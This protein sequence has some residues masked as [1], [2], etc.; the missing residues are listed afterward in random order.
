MNRFTM[1]IIS[2]LVLTGAVVPISYSEVLVA[3]TLTG[4][5]VEAIDSEGLKITVQVA[6]GG[7]KLVMPVIS[8][9]VMK[10]VAVGDKVSLELDVQGRVVKIIQIT[11]AQKEAPEPRG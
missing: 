2:V 1:A 3:T 6:G 7:D 9:E 11:P 5:R 4:S 10:G 8:P